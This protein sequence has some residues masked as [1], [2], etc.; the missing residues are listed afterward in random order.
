MDKPQPKREVAIT[1]HDEGTRTITFDAS[2]DAVNDFR[3]FGVIFPQKEVQFRA[4]LLV[5]AIFDFDEVLTYIQ[6]YNS[7]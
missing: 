4:T 2:K 1:F 3:E 7:P 5:S 6:N